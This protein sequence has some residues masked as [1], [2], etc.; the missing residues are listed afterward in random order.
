MG[1]RPRPDR[2]VLRRR[3]RAR[4][5]AGTVFAVGDEKQSIYSF[6]GADAGAFDR[7]RD[8]L[9]RAACAA[10]GKPWR[11]VRLDVSFRSTAPVLALVD[12]CSP[13]R[14]RRR[15]GRAGA[16][17][18]HVADRAG[19][20]GVVEL[21]PLAPRRDTAEARRRGPCRRRPAAR[22]RA[23]Q[24]LADTLAAW[25][26]EQTGGGVMLASRAARWRRRRAGAGAAPERF[27]AALVRAL[28][29]RGV[30]VAGARPAGAH[31]AAGGAGSAGAL[32]HAAAARG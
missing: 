14:G 19:Q 31:R 11:D 7:S 22:P 3:G 6:Q 15:R 18:R 23:P 12:A 26:R 28:K 5:P 29:A 17:L 16:A 2:R 30:P 8:R 21:W 13:T 4:R 24:R 20:A 1:H 9:R 32:R 27:C 25:S 10:P